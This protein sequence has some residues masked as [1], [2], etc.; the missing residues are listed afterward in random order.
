MS[1]VKVIAELGINHNGNIDTAKKMIDVAHTAGCDFIK[2]QKRTIDLVY[3]KEELYSKRESPWGTT[4]REQK[5][6]LEFGFNEYNIIDRYCREK[7]IGW[8]ASPWD[9]ESIEFLSSFKN[10]AYLKV[11]SALITNEEYLRECRKSPKQIILSTGMSTMGM[12]DNAVS[13]LGMNKISCIM[14]CTS[15]YPSKP[16]ELNLRCIDIFKLRYR[17]ADIGFSNH[18]PGIIYMPI[19]VALGAT[20][21][22]YHLTLDRSSYGSDQSASIEPEGAFKLNKYI[23]GVEKALGTGEKIIYESELPIIKKLRK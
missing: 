19:A 18:N 2:L 23:R 12:V 20:W 21:I 7:G 15:T 16:E 4:F 14:H 5:E 22:E 11:P 6:G 10:C 17:W 13:I 9:L 8:F 1:K 3:S